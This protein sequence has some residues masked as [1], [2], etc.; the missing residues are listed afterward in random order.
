MISGGDDEVSVLTSS[1]RDEDDFREI[2]DADALFDLPTHL[3]DLID[4]VDPLF[5]GDNDEKRR[6]H[7]LLQVRRH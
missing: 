1:T 3:L 4:I 6:A 7:V 2:D 5:E